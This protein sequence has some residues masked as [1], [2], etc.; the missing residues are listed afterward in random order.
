MKRTIAAITVLLLFLPGSVLA[1]PENEEYYSTLRSH[2]RKT[3]VANAN[4]AS[5]SMPFLMSP[6][7]NRAKGSIQARGQ[8]GKIDVSSVTAAQ[9]GA[10]CILETLNVSGPNSKYVPKNSKAKLHVRFVQQIHGMPIEGAS[11]VVHSDAGGNVFAINGELLDD[12]TVPSAKPT[13][14]SAKAIA[15]A[16]DESR[17]PSMFHDQCNAPSLTIVRGLDDGKAHLAWTCVVRYDVPGEDGYDKPY[18]DKIFAKA[19]GEAGLIQIHPLIYGALD[20]DTRNCGQTTANCQTVSTSKTAINSDDNAIND[21]HNYAIDTYDYY[22]TKFGRDSIDNRGMTLISRVNY[23]IRYNS[24]FWDGSQMTYGGGDGDTFIPLSQDLDIVAHEITHGVTERESGLI[25]KNE[26][27]ESY[28]VVSRH[29][30]YYFR[31]L[32]YQTNRH[33]LRTSTHTQVRSTRP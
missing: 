18:R 25:Y 10:R 16:L 7:V 32:H 21:A 22:F 23:N 9:A 15:V 26:S 28:I 14:D 2:L 3:Q 8:F 12:S 27:G 29:D 20:M 6:A 1:G 30:A 5:S 33:I 11:I 17:V 13:I 31:E 24:A 19:D 4:A